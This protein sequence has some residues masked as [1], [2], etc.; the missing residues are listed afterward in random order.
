MGIDYNTDKYMEYGPMSLNTI[1]KKD[2]KPHNAKD[3]YKKD[4][5]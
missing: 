1:Y 4:R 5:T 2:Y 3:Y